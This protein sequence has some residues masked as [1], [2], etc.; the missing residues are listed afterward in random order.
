VLPKIS[1]TAG[2]NI[3]ADQISFSPLRGKI[4]IKNLVIGDPEQPICQIQ[5]MRSAAGVL[6][7]LRGT[8]TID[9][10]Q[11]DGVNISLDRNNE[12]KWNFLPD[13]KL[14]GKAPSVPA[15]KAPEKSPKDMKLP[16][17][18]LSNIKIN[19]LNLVLNIADVD[20][21]KTSRISLENFNL[22]LPELKNGSEGI[23]ENSAV[24]KVQSGRQVNLSNSRFQAQIKVLLDDNSF[25]EKLI[26]SSCLDNLTG[27]LNQVS[28]KEMGLALVQ[29]I[30][31][32]LAPGKI[33]LT[34]LAVELSE[35]SHKI[36]VIKL[37]RPVSVDFSQDGMKISKNSSTINTVIN[38]FTLSTVNPF[39]PPSAK[40]KF[41]SGT[42]NADL[43]VVFDTVQ[44]EISLTG[45]SGIH[46]LDME[47]KNRR[48]NQLH[49]NQDF[50]IR[51][52]REMQLTIK[53]LSTV[54]KRGK[55]DFLDAHLSG[56]MPVPVNS[57]QINLALHSSHTD[58][59]I[60]EEFLKQASVQAEKQPG[61]ETEKDD[62]LELSS[63]PEPLE[64][65]PVDTKGLNLV[66][67]IKMNRIT[68]GPHL[69]ANTD[70]LLIVKDNIIRTNPANVYLNDTKINTLAMINLGEAD[71][72]SYHIAQRFNDLSV[73]PFVK[74]FVKN[75]EYQAI[76]GTIDSFSA[77]FGGKGFTKKN[78]EKY[79]NGAAV[80]TC[81]GIS[82]PVEV[83]ED[84][85]VAKFIFSPLEAINS[86]GQSVSD[87][88]VLKSFFNVFKT[89][90]KIIKNKEPLEFYQGKLSLEV[91]NG[92]L[93]IEECLFTGK[94]VQEMLL[95]G[96]IG[97]D[98]SIDVSSHVKISGWSFPVE[99]GGK[100]KKP[101]P[102]LKKLA[103]VFFKNNAANLLNPE[104]IG[105]MLD[106]FLDKDKKKKKK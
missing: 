82:I 70:I 103:K 99:I 33:R 85:R 73:R 42:L 80:S 49:I 61:P 95:A 88:N 65:P 50:N 43:N 31:L 75:R 106:L 76:K 59:K 29:D 60:L 56:T 28:L 87:V 8:V 46:N 78:L 41:A 64:P 14:M 57:G 10:C 69:Y 98:E 21:A 92:R 91:K 34:N 54:L 105:G 20:P 30:S 74:T 102:N 93:K 13:R 83:K 38:K 62:N 58:L 4:A 1:K 17:F 18:D 63:K 67:E 90:E 77:K 100:L 101:K 48:L 104:N 89:T 22:S 3:K 96:T 6:A 40:L 39:I 47:V 27:S 19:N 26:V 12:G 5:E 16:R 53:K 9:Y 66:A 23:I 79:L 11:L 32:G 2:I 71:G 86:V 94:E 25:P 37:S 44:Q 51:M 72:Y 45:K 15:E 68:Y 55:Q 84:S 81:S 35:A 97:L 7:S 52:S 24:I 36:V